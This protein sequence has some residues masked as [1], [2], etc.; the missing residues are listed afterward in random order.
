MPRTHGISKTGSR[1]YGISRYNERKR[2]NVIGA[3][4]ANKLIVATLFDCNIDSELFKQWIERELLTALPP[5]SVFVIDNA[6]FHKNPEIPKILRSKGHELLFLPP[7]SPQ[8]NSIEHEWANSKAEKRKKQCS[9]YDLF[10]ERLNN[11]N[12]VN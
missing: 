9:V 6:K 4:Y 7:Y 10:S 5:R 3:Q 11:Q 8:L 2:T 12:I 1:S